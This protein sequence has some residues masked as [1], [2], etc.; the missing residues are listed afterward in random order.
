MTAKILLSAFAAVAGVAV[1]AQTLTVPGGS[2]LSVAHGERESI[3]PNSLCV[4]TCEARRNGSGIVLCGASGVSCDDASSW[5]GWKKETVVFRTPGNAD[6]TKARVGTYNSPAG[7]QFRNVTVRK[8][9]AEHL[10]K[11]GIELGCGESIIGNEYTFE[12]QYGSDG[13]TDSRVLERWRGAFFNTDRWSMNTSAEIVYAHNINGRNFLSAEIGY[14]ANHRGGAFC[15]EA[16]KNGTDWTRLHL[17]TNATSVF[18]QVPDSLFPTKKLYVR[19]KGVEGGGLQLN[20][21]GLSAKIDGKAIFIS[22]STIYRN[23]NKEVISKSRS[24]A[25][26]EDGFGEIVAEEGGIKFWRASSGWKVSRRRQAP[27][28]TAKALVVRAAANEAESVQLVVTPQEKLADVRVSASTL[29]MAGKKGEEIAQSAIE[30]R[31]VGYV[32]VRQSTDILG[33]RGDWP[34]PLLPQDGSRLEVKAGENQP[35]W[36]TVSVPKTARGGRYKGEICVEAM[37]ECGKSVTTRIPLALEVFNFTL[38]DMMTLKATFG[39]N[40]VEV[41]KWHR[42]RSDKERRSTVD[43]YHRMFSAYRIAPRRLAPYDDWEPTWDKSAGENAPEKWEPVFDW[44]RWDAEMERQFST[45]RF[46]CFNM[47]PWRFWSGFGDAFRRPD[48]AGI[49]CD[50]PAYMTL[51]KK[52]LTKVGEHLREK[53][54]EDKAFIYWYDEPTQNTYTNVIAGMKL[55]KETMPGVKRLLTEQPE[56][57]LLGNVDIWC[58]MPHYLHTEH[59]SACRKA[60]EE[61]WWYLCTEPKAPYFGEFI[62]RAGSELRLWGWASWKTEIKGILMWSATYWS[63][64]AAY[65]DVKKPQNPYEDPMAWVSG[66]Q[67][68]PGER[69]PWGNGDGRFIYPPLKCVGDAGGT[70]FISDEPVPTVRLA[71]VRDGVEDFEYLTILKALSPEHPLLAVPEEIHRTDIDYNIDPSAMERHRIKIARAIEELSKKKEE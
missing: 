54:W 25:L 35:F 43:N 30:V 46:N 59:E 55:L 16:S 33:C 32:T 69:K 38:P 62:D 14:G 11:D 15:C 28:D 21:Y 47:K 63:S 8:A 39:M 56:K 20:K 19:F 64:R 26:Y 5:S 40:P 2:G 61:F 13:H 36:I 7:A 37:T 44:T 9:T 68:Q 3:A 70:D 29:K 12:S 58:P 41:S 1:S 34:D 48:I 22:G 53:G 27:Q 51:L 23:A 24:P 49:G 42:A 52:Y 4:M 6:W 45:Y 60:G 10:L 50:H 18:V 17:M 65:P 31:R 57:E 66:G 67:A 71:M